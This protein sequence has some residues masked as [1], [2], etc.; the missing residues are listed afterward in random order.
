MAQLLNPIDDKA[1]RDLVIKALEQFEEDTLVLDR[2][3]TRWLNSYPNRWVVV[4]G[5]KLICHSDT[6]EGALRLA[7]AEGAPRAC[8]AIEYLSTNPRRM[9]L[10]ACP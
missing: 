8:V 6:L 9:I 3:R 10:W 1:D 4:Y 5:G 2:N 7:D